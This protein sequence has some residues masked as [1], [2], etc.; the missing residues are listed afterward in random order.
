MSSHKKNLCS[1]IRIEKKNDFSRMCTKEMEKFS[2][3]YITHHG[4]I[5][6]WR[7]SIPLV[8]STFKNSYLSYSLPDFSETLPICFSYFSPLIKAKFL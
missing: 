5:A 8:I 6:N 2:L 3:H 7:I 1:T 4:R